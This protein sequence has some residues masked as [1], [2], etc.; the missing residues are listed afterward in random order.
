MAKLDSLGL[1]KNT[2]IVFW[3]DHG[4]H[5]GEK[6]KWSKHQSL[7]EIGTRVPL[8]VVDPGAAGNGKVCPRVVQSLD[9]Y[10]TL[11]ELC[12]LPKPDGLNGASLA[13]LLKDPQQKWDRPAYT[14][15]GNLKNVN[16]AVRTEK[17]RYA[18]YVG[19]GG[20][21][22][23]FDEAADPHELKNLADDPKHAATVAEMKALLKAL[24]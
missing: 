7:F 19:Q 1:R 18:E 2:V 8:I 3:G 4:Y 21:A 23:L 10:P 15:G 20:G 12:G 14:F 6:G 16:R 9:L 24:P 11:C 5:L 22:M 13:P 17:Y